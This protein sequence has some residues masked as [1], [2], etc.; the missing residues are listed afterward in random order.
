MNENVPTEAL[1]NAPKVY[2]CRIPVISDGQASVA[3]LKGS[4]LVKSVHKDA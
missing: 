1:T 2:L 3:A 4:E